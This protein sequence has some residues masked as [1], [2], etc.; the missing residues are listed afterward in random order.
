MG[1]RNAAKPGGLDADAALE[2]ALSVTDGVHICV[3]YDVEGFNALYIDDRTLGLYGGE[4]PA[5]D[6]FEEVHSYVNVDF[7][8]R[9]LFEDVLFAAGEV[10]AFVTYMEYTIA[11]RFLR[12][13]DGIF[14]ALDPNAPV[15][16][17]LQA[18]REALSDGGEGDEA[19]RENGEDR[20]ETGD[21]AV[22]DGD[23]GSDR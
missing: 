4:E 15:T 1:I 20:A 10:R 5:L 8:E 2:A 19:E 14:F 17:M 23:D 9:D 6:H 13:N 16:E 21:G 22:G 11:V 7:T 3:E 18:I 12:E